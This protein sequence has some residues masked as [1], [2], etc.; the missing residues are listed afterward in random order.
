MNNLSQKNE[1]ALSILSSSV[2]ES[3]SI[4]ETIK[5]TVMKA[6][7]PLMRYFDILDDSSPSYVLGYN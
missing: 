1:D 4:K 3:E 2:T 7:A 5:D 6:E